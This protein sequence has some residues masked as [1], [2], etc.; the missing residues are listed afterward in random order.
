MGF[1]VEKNPTAGICGKT[2]SGSRLPF[3]YKSAD[4][5]GFAKIC[6][7]AELVKNAWNSCGFVFLL[8]N[9]SK[10]NYVCDIRFSKDFNDL[11]LSWYT[12]HTV[13]DDAFAGLLILL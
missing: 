2:C 1:I 12:K 4:S 8:R 3:F 9:S 5:C 11:I 10:L 13:M 6:N 7:R